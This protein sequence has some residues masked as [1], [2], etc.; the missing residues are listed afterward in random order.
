VSTR[1]DLVSVNASMEPLPGRCPQEELGGNHAPRTTA[2]NRA[3]G[4][5]DLRRF[6]AEPELTSSSQ[7]GAA[8][9][10]SKTVGF[11]LV[12][13]GGRSIAPEFPPTR[14]SEHEL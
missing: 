10:M 6:G 8:T 4:L 7:A 13:A 3:R 14:P 1:Y 5:A 2:G 9:A 12:V 11:P